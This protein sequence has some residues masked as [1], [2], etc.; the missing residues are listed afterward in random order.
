[1]QTSNVENTEALKFAR[2]DDKTAR[3]FY[4]MVPT[5]PYGDWCRFAMNFSEI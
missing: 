1:V 3:R 2:G 5:P 4:P